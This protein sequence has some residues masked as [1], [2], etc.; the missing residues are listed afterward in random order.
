MK[1]RKTI[2]MRK[3]KQILHWHKL[4]GYSNRRIAELV[5]ANKETVNRYVNKAKA[6]SKSIDEL[7]AMDDYALD[8]RLR[9]GNPAYPDRR[10]ETFKELLPYFVEQM[11]NKKNHM[12]LRLLWE[13][14]VQEHP[15]DHY[16]L[17]QFRYHYR[18]NTKAK[19]EVSTVLADLHEPGEKLY[20]D[21]SGDR[22]SY[23][24]T[25]I[26]EVVYP[27]MFVACLP[28]SDYTFAIA[29]PSQSSEDFVYAI[30]QCLKHI[31]GCPK[32]IVPDNLKAAVIKADRHAPT[33]NKLL[34]DMGN[35]YGIAIL[36]AR[37]K[38]PKDKS[39]VEGMV[40]ILYHRVYAPLRNQR[41]FSLEELNGAI[42]V[43]VQKHNQTRMQLHPYTREERFLSIEKPSLL[44]LPEKDFEIRYSTELTVQ[45][46]CCIL[47]GRDKHY[48]S[49]PCQYV[50]QQV[51]VDYTRT[52]VKIYACGELV[53]TH[54]RDT[55]PGQYTI[56]AK[57]M[58]SNSEQWRARSK[59]YYISKAQSI[60]PELAD[61]FVMLFL[62]DNRPE[63]VHYRTC[64]ALLHLQR[65]T[66]PI[67]FRRAC[68][69]ALDREIYSYHFVRNIVESKGAGL[70][71]GQE[72][73]SPNPSHS[74]IRGARA[75]M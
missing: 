38:K 39:N 23:F 13:E 15:D 57:H 44:P 58:A 25:T 47:L 56:Q 17:T 11:A 18:Q 55:T 61:L 49:V 12:T 41:F 33:L 34:E 50:G 59:E 46:N 71:K 4:G 65:E 32:I 22:L 29:V 52:I 7:L 73:K 6:D 60:M 20:V 63:E 48:Y 68:Q 70:I 53:T 3:V 66:D 51:Q 31:G 30:S 5:G 35:H 9:C 26:G 43:Q 74:N 2:E 24:D 42:T 40:K 19:K 8:V 1:K 21:F 69:V 16:S 67:L 75:Y 64:D 28:A 72:V 37:A 14:Y 27:Q 54:R 10:F 62:R 45:P 36:P